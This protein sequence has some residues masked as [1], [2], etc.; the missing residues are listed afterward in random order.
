[1]SVLALTRPDSWNVPLLL[2]V[3]G[4]MVLVGAAATG[5]LTALMSS[6]SDE[7][8]WLRRVSFRS[9][10]FV[11]LPAYIVMRVGAEWVRTKEFPEGVKEPGWI[12]IGYMTADG[13]ALILLITLILSG[14]AVRRGSGGMAKVA[15]ILSAIA[16]VA[17]LITVWAM[18]GKP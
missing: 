16:V 2:H 11:A 4:A 13:G 18:S 10:L 8:G 15:G 1:M 5:S 6:G 17:W 7:G 14:L 12:G 9:F 3:L